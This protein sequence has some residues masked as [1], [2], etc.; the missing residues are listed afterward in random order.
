M[1]TTELDFDFMAHRE[2]C[3]EKI[4]KDIHSLTYQEQ[5]K[6]YQSLIAKSSLGKLWQSLQ[7]KDNQI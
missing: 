3:Q 5:I 6:Y 7:E 4:Y 1:K 2:H